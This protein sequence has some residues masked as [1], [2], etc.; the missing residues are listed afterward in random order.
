MA[1]RIPRAAD[2]ESEGDGM[3]YDVFRVCEGDRGGLVDYL[4]TMDG[5]TLNE[6]EDQARLLFDWTPGQERI[7]VHEKEIGEDDETP[8]EPTE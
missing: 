3:T 2:A 1:S 5:E 7:E 6:V 8:L 4:G